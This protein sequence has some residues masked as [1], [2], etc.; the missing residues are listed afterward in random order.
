[1]TIEH[2]RIAAALLAGNWLILEEGLEQI[3][4]IVEQTNGDP[5]AVAAKLGRPLQNTRS[6]T[7][8]GDVAV[9]PVT[10][11]IFRYANLF[12]E[13][14]GATS[15]QQLASDF[16]AALA[17]EKVSA[18][19][20]EINSPGGE[21]TGI[22]E[23]ADMVF[24]ARG[25]K[26]VVAY[27]E[28]YGA[29]AAYWIASAAERLVINDT[30]SVGS[31]G[32]LSNVRKNR[33]TDTMEIVSTQSPHKRPDVST[34]SGK[35]QIQNY[36][37]TLAEVFIA[38]VA[39]HRG[40]SDETVRSDFG[41]GGL[42]VG[43]NAVDAG[44]ADAVGSLES[45]IADLSAG[46]MPEAK[47]AAPKPKTQN[48]PPK[49]GDPPKMDIETLQKEHPELAAQLIAQGKAEGVKE[50]QKAGE[51]AAAQR[52]KEAEAAEAQRKADVRAA[53]IP[54]HEALIERL[55]ADG[56]TTGAEAVA[57]VHAAEKD[58]RTGTAKGLREDAPKAL[59][60]PAAPEKGNPATSDADPPSA[61]RAKA[62]WEANADIQ[63]EFNHLADVAKAANLGD[64]DPKA[65]FAA[66]SDAN[67]K[68]LV[69]RLN[70][71]EE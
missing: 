60:Q 63:A 10:G 18:I 58:L 13:I 46:R 62:E 70:Q 28:G 1:M 15:V 8:R 69:R 56:K 9:M 42:L 68:G 19:A 31:I 29:S 27:V 52:Q 21:I 36:V 50:G 34:E 23:F 37:D 47:S 11:P 55:A 20:L 7:M 32:V 49:K 22:S 53:L 12:T 4:A 17:D 39:R 14:S 6:V 43:K 54:G 26:P 44:M 65:A 3:I 5:E 40:V 35:K 64:F 67:S 61:D 71:P 33:Q 48:P 2:T 16:N 45:V 51:D 59:N 66:Y 25:K 41:Q 30:G 38:A 24:A 57:L